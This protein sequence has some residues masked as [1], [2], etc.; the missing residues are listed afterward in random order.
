MPNPVGYPFELAAIYPTTWASP[1]SSY[2][3]RPYADVEVQLTG[4]F[5]AYT[6]QRSL[7]GTNFVPCNAY[8]KNGNAITSITAAGIYRLPGNGYLKLAS[9]SGATVTIRVGG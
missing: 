4:T 2:D 7:D 1:S 3:A 8:D 6:P 9:G 5:T